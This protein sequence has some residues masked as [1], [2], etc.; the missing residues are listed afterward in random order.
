MTPVV[1]LSGHANGAE[2]CPLSGNKRTW[3]GHGLMSASD[4]IR[5][6]SRPICCGAQ[7]IPLM[8]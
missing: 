8:W 4:P 5:K 1:A 2:Q 6:W 3:S 7:Q